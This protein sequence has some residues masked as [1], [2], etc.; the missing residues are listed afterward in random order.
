MERILVEIDKTAYGIHKHTHKHRLR[1][2]TMKNY[3]ECSQK[4]VCS[5][6]KTLLS[7]IWLAPKQP[8]RI[9]VLYEKKIINWHSL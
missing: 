8:N 7:R 2:V 1:F 9:I 3:Y 4:P 6:A 5:L